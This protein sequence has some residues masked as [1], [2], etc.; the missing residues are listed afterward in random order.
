MN[1]YSN[2]VPPKIK[3]ILKREAPENFWV[4][5]PESGQLVFHKDIEANLYV[6]P[7]SGYHMRCPVEARLE[8]SV[9]R[10][11]IRTDND[12][13]GADRPAQ[14]SRHQALRRQA[15][16][17][18]R[19]DRPPRRGDG[20]G[21]QSQGFAGHRRRAGLRI[22]GRIARHG[23][24]RGDRR[25][26][27]QC[28]REAHALHHLHRLGRRPHAGGHV[29]ADADAAHDDRGAAA[30]QGADSLYRRADQSDHR[31]RNRFLRDAGRYSDRRA[32]RDHRLRR[33]PRDRADDPRKTPRGVPAR[34]ISQGPRHDRHGRAAPGDAGHAGAVVRHAD[35]GA[36]A[37][38]PAV[39]A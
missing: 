17:I 23:G 19:Q 37:R 7:A 21:R 15:E 27:H 6:V 8:S 14:I 9:R 11:P 34:R 25:R 24:R 33:R 5:C 20:R 30:A 22:H 16:G 38:Q 4:K 32:G 26:R 13:R 2:V 1:W 29:L 3:A 31:R 28:A 18:S 12:A 36:G 39:A 10:R 35:Q